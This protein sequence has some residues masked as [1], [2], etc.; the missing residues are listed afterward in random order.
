MAFFPNCQNFEIIGGE[1]NEIKGNVNRYYTT[2]TYA[3]AG[4]HNYGVDGRASD[5]GT[6]GRYSQFPPANAAYR[7]SEQNGPARSEFQTSAFPHGNPHTFNRQNGG[8][9]APQPRAPSSV[10]SLPDPRTPNPD[11]FSAQFRRGSAGSYA[12]RAPSLQTSWSAPAPRSQYPHSASAAQSNGPQTW[13]DPNGPHSSPMP[14]P[15]PNNS[16]HPS[17]RNTTRGADTLSS[18]PEDVPSWSHRPSSSG[19]FPRANPAPQRGYTTFP[20]AMDVSDNILPRPIRSQTS[21]GGTDSSDSESE[22]PETRPRSNTHRTSQGGQSS[23][24]R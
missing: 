1:F 17:R 19:Q 11:D 12:P 21:D 24:W 9:A 6:G 22:N 4:S 5:A 16:Y 13:P 15:R 20:T 7:H 14:M 10:G 8:R 2:T 3:T 18:S 23:D